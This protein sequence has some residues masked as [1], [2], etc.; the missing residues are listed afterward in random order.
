METVNL[1]HYEQCNY[2][3]RLHGGD[4][5]KMLIDTGMLSSIKVAKGPVVLASLDNVVFKKPIY[6]GDVI[7]IVSQVD[8]IGNSSMEVEMKAFRGDEPIV[9]ATGVYVKVDDNVR[10]L[11]VGE[12]IIPVKDEERLIV[13]EAR[14]RRELRLKKLKESVPLEDPTEKLTVK[15]HNVIYV[16]P[17]MTYDGRLISA[18]KIVKLMDDLGG[19]LGL[20]LINYKGFKD[21][22]DT[23]VTVSVSDTAFLSPIKLGDVVEMTA[24]LSYVGKTS[25][26]VLIT[27]KTRNPKDGTS[28]IVTTAFFNYVR[29]GGD[30]RPKEFPP[31][32]PKNEYEKKMFESALA[33]RHRGSPYVIS[34]KERG[35]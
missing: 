20:S 23:V 14:K 1:V 35:Q 17:E 21:G 13:E 7:R 32:Y 24:G 34:E 16:T 4:M 11:A 6:L 28:R 33:R 19:M 27:V 5:L 12:K 30:G 10:P 3:G 22:S 15:L 8:Y 29:I 18:G 25:I 26:E 31:Y 2:M 9:T